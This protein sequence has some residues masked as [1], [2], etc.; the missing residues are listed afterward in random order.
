MTDELAPSVLGTRLREAR[1]ARGISQAIAAERIGVSRPTLIAVEQGR[2]RPLPAELVSLA[3]LYGRQ[4]HDLARPTPPVEALLAS[5]RIEPGKE[6]TEK[7]RAVEELQRLADDVTELETISSTVMPRNYPPTY[8]IDGLPIDMAA[9]QV[10]Q[11]ERRRLGLGDG[12]VQQLRTVLEGEVGLKIFAFRLPPKIAGLFTVAEPAGACIGLN[13]LHPFERQRWTLTHEWGHFLTSR[14]SAEITELGE[15]PARASERFAEAFAAHFLMPASSITHRFQTI[16][17][18]RD[19]RFTA[20]DLLQ[21]AAQYQVSAQACA[22]RLEDLRLVAAGWWSGLV[23]RG[24]KVVEARE[25]L[26]LETLARDDQ[27]LPQRM[28]YLAVEAYLEGKL[29]EG[30]LARLFQVDRV[31]VRDIVRRLGESSDVGSQGDLQSWT[32]A[33]ELANDDQD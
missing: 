21:L 24:L 16:R 19:G 20:A 25:K 5:F 11:S 28:Q 8:D 4:V 31:S 23:S 29:S 26:G 17:R 22:L 30:R 13:V 1:R 3:H 15:G 12:P 18:S 14:W 2:R 33:A 32:W 10:A 6:A 7:Q 9:E 27:L